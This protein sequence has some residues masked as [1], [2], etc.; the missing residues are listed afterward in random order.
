M[1]ERIQAT[2]PPPVTPT[3]SLR[4]P[5]SSGLSPAESLKAKFVKGTKRSLSDY[6]EFKDDRYWIDLKKMQNLLLPVMD[7][8][9]YQIIYMFQQEM[10]H[11]YSK[12]K[13]IMYSVFK[14]K[15]KTLKSK[16]VLKKFIKSKNAQ[17]LQRVL[18]KD[19]EEGMTGK[20]INEDLEDRW[21]NF[22]LDDC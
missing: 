16:L 20:L 2:T 14:A 10:R 17:E 13:S 6:P 8:I 15:F 5:I 1:I 7:V 3:T 11:L 12:N 19:Y 21:K 4:T 9:M 18:I 22:K